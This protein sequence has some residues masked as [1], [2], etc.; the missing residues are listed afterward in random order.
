MSV[1]YIVKH[2]DPVLRQVARPVAKITPAIERLLDDLA[3]TMYAADGVGLAAPQ[4]GISKRIAVVDVG[5][6]LI[7]LINPE[8]LETSGEQ[9][10]PEG[11]LSI[12]GVFGDVIRPARVR[13]RAQ[14]R[15][16]EWFEVEGEG[17]LARALLHE[18][19]HLNGVLFID[20]AH[21]LYRRDPLAAGGAEGETGAQAAPAEGAPALGRKA[22]LAGRT[23][24]RKAGDAG[25]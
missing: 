2:P 1:R 18:I 22:R 7:E 5:E 8:V 3:E 17:L 14:N 23:G 10:G 13:V 12:P 24:G 11:C 9:D 20:R 19:D 6:G 16:G 4:V 25:S 21:T 15:R